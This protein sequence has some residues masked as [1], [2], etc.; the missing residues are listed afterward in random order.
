MEIDEGIPNRNEK[1]EALGFTG[2]V[3]SKSVY[4]FFSYASGGA[5]MYL[6]RYAEWIIEWKMKFKL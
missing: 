5:L 6:S 1:N 2:M 3:C 4:Y